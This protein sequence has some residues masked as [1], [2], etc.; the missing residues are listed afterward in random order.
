MEKEETPLFDYSEFDVA[1]L[2][3]LA[4]KL[5]REITPK[6]PAVESIYLTEHIPRSDPSEEI[7]PNEGI[8][9]KT[10][11]QTYP[12]EAMS[13]KIPRLL[14]AR[15]LEQ[16]I[17]GDLDDHGPRLLRDIWALTGIAI[18]IVVLRVIAKIKIRKI[19]W[20]DIL[21]VSALCL[22]IVGS[23]LI[24][25]GIK[26]GFGRH[27]WDLNTTTAVPKVIMYDYLTQT[28]GIAGGTLGRI[29]F[30]VFVIQLLGTRRSHRVIL[31][32]IVGLQIVTNVMLIIILFVQC[33]G[34]GSA[35]WTQNGKD[36]CWDYRVQAYYG[37]YQG[38]FN[39]ATDLYLAVFSTYVFWNLNLKLRVK[40]G[41][42]TLLGLGIFAMAASVMKAVQT[43]VF[44]HADDD[45]TVATV[46][47][48]RWLFIEAYI[49]IITASIPCI[50]SLLRSGRG[51]TGS[52]RSAY[53][54]SSSYPGNSLPTPRSRRL[55]PKS[56]IPNPDNSS[57]DDILEGNNNEFDEVHEMRDSKK[58]VHVYV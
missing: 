55:T 4:S 49:V 14:Q 42:V 58:S 3:H 18:L 32:V 12:T 38:S 22:T 36:K 20:D 27:V 44:A 39:S 46:N 15:S 43:Q 31:W 33:P 25:V 30:I 54:L 34:H 1:A 37:Y 11:H 51:T 57:T 53:E 16:Q 56:L 40:L 8:V 29:S 45:P 17:R 28:F 5:R 6:N 52:G 48:D 50:R 2:C 10:S 47:Y 7:L 24:T 26:Y 23:A 21:M 9:P 35:I 13:P 19:G 41:L